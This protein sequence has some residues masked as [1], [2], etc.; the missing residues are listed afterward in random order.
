MNGIS[1]VE[2]G[3]KNLGDGE[4]QVKAVQ[5]E[6]D[7]GKT[8]RHEGSCRGNERAQEKRAG[9]REDGAALRTIEQ[10]EK[11]RNDRDNKEME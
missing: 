5:S 10:S 4:S 9:I 7:S 3:K 1:Q 6:T 2:K 11:R 8:C